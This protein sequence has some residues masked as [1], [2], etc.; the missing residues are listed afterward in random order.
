MPTDAMI[1]LGIL[2]FLFS[3]IYFT[4]TGAVKSHHYFDPITNYYDE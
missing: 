3:F 1:A 4:V 2:Y